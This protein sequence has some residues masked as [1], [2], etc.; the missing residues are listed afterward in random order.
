MK[1]VLRTAF[2]AVAC[3]VAFAGTAG[4]NAR[5]DSVLPAAVGG[6]CVLGPNGG[7]V[8]FWEVEPGK[9]YDLTITGVTECGNGGTD[10]TINVRINSSSAGNMD[11]VASKVVDGT[12]EFT[13]PVPQGAVCTMPIFYC[14][15]P[16]LTSSGLRVIT[17]DAPE[18]FQA[19]LRMASFGGNCLNPTGIA[20]SD[21][22]LTPTRSR[23]WAQVK[24]FYR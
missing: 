10:A 18:E 16:G 3:L 4:A 23:T 14:T 22:L 13:F 21:C 9:N 2:A 12:Y 17:K 5:L 15:T 24:S 8:Q 11:L 20:G 6:G 1:S 7:S 19:H